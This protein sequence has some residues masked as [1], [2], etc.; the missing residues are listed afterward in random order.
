[1]YIK[2]HRTENGNVLACCDRELIGEKIVFGEIVV[3]IEESFYRGRLV[4]EKELLEK[5]TEYENIN[6]FGKKVVSL[7]IKKGVVNKKN[8]TYINKIPHIQIYRL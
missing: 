6:G 2:E 4:S 8:V 1:M 5:V 7:L 3:E